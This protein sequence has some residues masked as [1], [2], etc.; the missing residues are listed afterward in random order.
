[1]FNLVDTK[2]KNRI[3]DLIKNDKYGMSSISISKKLKINRITLS[4]YL[5]V[6]ESEC[7]IYHHDFGMTKAWFVHKTPPVMEFFNGNNGHSVKNVLNVLGDGVVVIDNNNK[8]LWTN[9]T[10]SD[11]VE[12]DIIGN[13]FSDFFNEIERCNQNS[14]FVCAMGKKCANNKEYVCKCATATLEFVDNKEIKLKSTISPILNSDQ[15][16]IGYIHL[17][18]NH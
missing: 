16:T 3:L 4:K 18:K 17:I 7:L 12:K 14:S 2:I 11:M 6:M 1:M 5:N 9:K 13:K 10:A 8:I 15:A